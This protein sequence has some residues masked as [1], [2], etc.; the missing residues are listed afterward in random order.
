MPLRDNEAH[1]LPGDCRGNAD[2]EDGVA[3]GRATRA[4]VDKHRVVARIGKLH[5]AQEIR[6]ARGPGN[7]EA[8]LPPL[9]IRDGGVAHR[10]RE[11]DRGADVGVAADRLGDDLG[12]I[13]VSIEPTKVGEVR[14]VDGG[15]G[16][17]DE[18]GTIASHRHGLHQVV[19]A[20]GGKAGVAGAIGIQP[21]HPA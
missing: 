4:V 8:L 11:A 3:A 19:D 2:V 16:P 13:S 14:A 21:G 15:E 9:V 17:A 18:G 20:R 1:R 6:H 12:G 5:V 7:V 10:H